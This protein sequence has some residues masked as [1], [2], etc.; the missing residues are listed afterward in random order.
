[1]PATKPWEFHP[2]LTEGRLVAVAQLIASGRDAALEIYDPVR[3]FNG[4][5]LGCCAYQFGRVRIERAVEEQSLPWLGISRGT[6]HFIFQ[7]GAVPVRFYRDDPDDP[8]EKVLQQSEFESK[9]LS[10]ALGDEGDG[11]DSFRLIVQTGPGGELIRISFLALR[12]GEAVL[13]WD[14][15]LLRDG[16]RAPLVV[17]G[18]VPRDQGVALPPPT[19]TVRRRPAAKASGG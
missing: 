6:R 14:V 9:Q 18:A 10:L 13:V 1:M 12:E 3:G 17:V 16:V 4:W 11:A 5:L 8:S 7:I 2:D 15:P 19:V